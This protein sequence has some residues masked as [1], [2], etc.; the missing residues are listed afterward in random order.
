MMN[1]PSTKKLISVIMPAYNEEGNLPRAYEEVTAAMEKITDYEYEVIVIDNASTDRTPELV[2]AFCEKDSRWKYVRFSRNF[3]GET[4]IT[5][6]L[7]LARGDAAINVFS[8]MQDPPE[9]VIDFIRKWEEGYDVVYGVLQDR[10][11]N[12]RMRGFAARMAYRF[13]R[14]MSDVDI[15]ENVADFRLIDRKVIDAFNQFP[16]RQRYVRGLMAWVGFK[17]CPMPYDRR[18]RDWGDSKAPFWWCINFAISAITSFSLKPLKMFTVF[19]FIVTGISILMSI[20]YALTNWFSHFMPFAGEDVAGVPTVLVLL[21]WNLAIMSLG[22]GI[23]GEYIGIIFHETK[24]RPICIV[25]E[26]ANLDR[27]EVLEATRNKN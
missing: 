18:A 10:Q 6:G 1:E 22:F 23:L 14:W 27:E 4:S 26:M 9:R 16:E 17:T 11:D 20:W 12:S 8:D 5:V 25:S 2:K 3:G 13:I 19:G 7:R 15:P 21:S 24:K